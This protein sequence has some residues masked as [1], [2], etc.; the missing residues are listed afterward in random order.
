[1]ILVPHDIN[2][3]NIGGYKKGSNLDILTKFAESGL[4]CMKVEEYTHS[5]A[6]KCA[7]SLNTSAPRFSMPHLRAIVRD[8]NVYLINT[9]MTK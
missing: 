7:S 5:S 4:E 2:E 1:M 8:G 6:Y 3:L 9:L